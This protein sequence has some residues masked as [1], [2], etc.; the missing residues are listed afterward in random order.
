MSKQESARNSLSIGTLQNS[1][2]AGQ[3]KPTDVDLQRLAAMARQAY[4]QRHLKNCLA[5]TKAL[6]LVDS[7]HAEARALQS[8]IQSDIR[9]DLD[10]AR[11]LLDDARHKGNHVQYEKAA[12]I[13]LSRV[14]NVDPANEEA[15]AL[16]SRIKTPLTEIMSAPAIS[17]PAPVTETRF[18]PIV[19]SETAVLV[20][21]PLA[22]A[23]ASATEKSTEPAVL[24]ETPLAGSP[25][26]ATL[27][28]FRTEAHAS[29]TVLPEPSSDPWAL[30]FSGAS[31]ETEAPVETERPPQTPIALEDVRAGTEKRYRIRLAVSRSAIPIVLGVLAVIA[32]MLL[33]SRQPNVPAVQQ[34]VKTAVS[35]T[36]TRRVDDEFSKDVAAAPANDNYSESTPV[37]ALPAAPKLP[38][39]ASAF[40]P[41]A[42][43][44][45]VPIT[46]PPLTTPPSAGVPPKPSPV[47]KRPATVVAAIKTGS[48]AISSPTATD[49]YSGDKYLGSTPITLELSAGT[50]MLEYRHLDQRKSVTH[51]VKA[52][53]ATTTMVTFEVT[54]Q[55]NARPWAQV[56]VEGG[57]RRS[58]GQT[59]L[60]NVQVPIGSVLIF[61]NPN[62]P[63]KNYRVTGKET[64]I[65]V[66]FP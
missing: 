4:E 19:V 21:L 17:I 7:E 59:P 9:Q 60:S 27:A 64:A 30:A 66:V 51:V 61:E 34:T 26:P 57:Q 40:I 1:S 38:V 12:Q 8:L 52:S 6:L 43:I 29:P 63:G 58:L 14:F 48:L 10:N 50:H 20:P 16:L 45:S 44:S 22:P 31:V 15:S 32:G 28:P 5:V 54:V 36:A 56:F 23:A 65:Q 46:T 55:I 2:A 37:N 18:K 49:I 24:P 3:G 39:A 42:D 25:A 33:R 53:E 62:F 35:S 41:R 13:V 47:P 11:T